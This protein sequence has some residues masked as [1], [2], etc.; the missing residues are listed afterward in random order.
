MQNEKIK[1]KLPVGMIIILIYL[2]YI[3]LTLLFTFTNFSPAVQLG[4]TVLTGAS[5]IVINVIIAAT[6]AMSVLGIFKRVKWAWKLTVGYEIFSILLSLAN[7]LSFMKNATMY[8]SYY[9]A[10]LDSET[11]AI[12]TPEMI[13]TGLITALIFGSIISLV[14]IT[15]LLKK[16]SFFVN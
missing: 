2:S 13:Q 8:N 14:I 7:L 1:Q 16:R 10:N 4:P 12:M 5:A 9:Q 15:Y 3:L 6:L 11:L